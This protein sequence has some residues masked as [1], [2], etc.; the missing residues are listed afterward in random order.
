MANLF[1]ITLGTLLGLSIGIP[2]LLVSARQRKEERDFEEAAASQALTQ[3][4][5]GSK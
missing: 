2:I 5:R 4:L 3:Y 1:V